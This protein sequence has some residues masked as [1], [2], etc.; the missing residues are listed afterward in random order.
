MMDEA[1]KLI[2]TQLLLS[3]ECL[4]RLQAIKKALKENSAGEGVTEAVRAIE[5][6]LLKLGQ[7]EKAMQAF[8]EKT[9]KKRM[10]AYAASMPDSVERDAVMRLLA[11]IQGLDERLQ[12]EL[13]STQALLKR[14]KEFVD[15]HI[16]VMTQTAANDTYA[17][18]GAPEVENRRGIK[19]FDANV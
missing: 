3:T 6:T 12:R 13:A 10:T 4:E 19:M 8:L 7:L 9:G 18:P 14:S 5:P 1:V 16:N 15:F 11:R 17:P 2:R